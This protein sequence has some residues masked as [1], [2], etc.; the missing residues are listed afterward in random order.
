MIKSMTGFGK[1]ERKSR[2]GEITVEIRTINHKFFEMMARIPSN[3]NELEDKIKDTLQEKVR[4]GRVHVAVNMDSNGDTK[5]IVI[6]KELAKKY[7]R[8]LSE[9]KD[10]LKV[11]DDI[12][13]SNIINMPNVIEYE[14]LPRTAAKVWPELK[15]ALAD[16]IKSLIISREREGKL[17]YND[18]IRH[19]RVIEK[20]VEKIRHVAPS[21]LKRYR[22][23]I[24]KKTKDILKDKDI[25]IGRLRLEEEVAKFSR[26]C[27]ISEELTRLACHVSAFREALHSKDEVGR[28]MDFITQELHREA[29]TIASK[30]N[31]Y[32]IQEEVIDIKSAIEKIRE[33]IQ[34]VE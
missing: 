6:N 2:F 28:R 21:V 31:D 34:N 26:D 24:V 14:K 16:A 9:L 23:D 3:I 30:A 8:M 7:R 18:I 1:A 5:N 29:N 20:N 15:G 22:D 25:D 12:G 19:I 33:Q 17:L 27:D 10:D 13:L 32:K 11:R 4:R